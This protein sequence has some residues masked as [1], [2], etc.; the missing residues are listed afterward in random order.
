MFS[1]DEICMIGSDYPTQRKWA[2]DK[3]SGDS[4]ESL[5]LEL[6]NLL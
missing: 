6:E 2:L 5:F 4:A 1:R 3:D